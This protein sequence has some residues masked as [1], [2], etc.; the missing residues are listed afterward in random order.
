MSE[1]GGVLRFCKNDP[2]D[3]PFMAHG[4]YDYN[5]RRV[6]AMMLCHGATLDARDRYRRMIAHKLD[7]ICDTRPQHESPRGY[8]RLPGTA[9]MGLWLHRVDVA[10]G[11]PSNLKTFV[12]TAVDRGDEA[13]EARVKF[14]LV[15]ELIYGKINCKHCEM[16]PQHRRCRISFRVVMART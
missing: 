2:A 4:S 11:N 15:I 13:I 7:R 5:I 8:P 3:V 6:L 16:V 10:R 9:S 14:K 1:S 12:C